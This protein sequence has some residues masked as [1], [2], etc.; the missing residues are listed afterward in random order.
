MG[1]LLRSSFFIHINLFSASLVSCHSLVPQTT[2]DYWMHLKSIFWLNPCTL[3]AHIICTW[4][5]KYFVPFLEVMLMMQTTFFQ[6]CLMILGFILPLFVRKWSLHVLQ[7]ESFDYLWSVFYL[8]LVWAKLLLF[9]YV[10]T[11][12]QLP[13]SGVEKIHTGLCHSEAFVIKTFPIVSL[14]PLWSVSQCPKE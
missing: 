13:S 14:G 8:Y 5:C 9:T 2:T 12:W 10:C 7:W 4:F 1:I 11:L 3:H 6:M